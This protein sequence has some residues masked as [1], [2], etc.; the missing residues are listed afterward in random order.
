MGTANDK[1]YTAY[2]DWIVEHN[3]DVFGTLNFKPKLKPNIDVAQKQW[4]S[5]WNK[6]D[7]LIYGRT[8]VS[9]GMRVERFVFTQFGSQND[10]PHIHFLAK[11]PINT[12]DFCVNLN[13]LWKTEFPAA[14]AP[15]CNE[16]LP[17]IHDESAAKYSLH[18]YWR[19]NSETFNAQLSHL[20]EKHAQ[21]RTDAVDRLKRSSKQLWR[22][23]AE[24]AFPNHNRLAKARF[25][26]HVA[27]PHYNK[28]QVP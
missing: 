6:L 11:S 4:S 16:I 18:E 9:N 5:V 22:I 7:Q 14:A 25:K 24:L 27:K 10:N 1:A 23:Q 2:K 19:N 3:W 28:R 26:Q 17:L 12:K 21:V 13:A 15:V 20:S 8:G